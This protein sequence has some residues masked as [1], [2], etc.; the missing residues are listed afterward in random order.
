[1]ADDERLDQLDDQIDEARR[2]AEDAGLIED[3]DDEPRFFESGEKGE[4]DDDQ[5]IAPP[6]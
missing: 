2:T 4:E 1:M 3:E 5:T 6:G